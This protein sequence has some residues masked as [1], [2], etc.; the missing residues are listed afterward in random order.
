M[1]EPKIYIGIDVS[2]AGLD[3]ALHPSGE[4]WHLTNSRRGIHTLIRR[5][6]G[7]PIELLVVEA[8][9]GYEAELVEI[10]CQAG[11]PVSRV[12]PGRVRKFAQGL[13]W[14]AKTDKIDAQLLALFGEKAQP[15]RLVL[16]SPEEKHLSA[17]LKRRRQ[18]LD[19]LTAEQNRTDLA[20]PHIL[21]SIHSVIQLLQSQVD[22]LDAQ[23]QALIDQTPTLKHKRDLL[24]SVPGVGK[25]LS[26]AL[27]AQLPELGSCDRKQ[28]AALA[29][30]APFNHDSG[31]KRGKRFIRGGRSFLRQIL[32]MATITATRFNPV[33]KPFYQ[34]LLS[35][36]K[37]KKVAIIACMR[38]LL[39][40]LNAMLRSDSPWQ[41]A[42]VS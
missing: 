5:L 27:I 28:I 14:L 11:L 30:V 13:N 19:M 42:F 35:S 6:Q 34:H 39:T 2:K 21:A 29:G 31:P 33:L 22:D 17:L 1:K 20:D 41:P 26:A 24:Q 18:L 38:K 10:L 8:T 4:S 12:N 40:I 23:I 36:G 25:V 9:G 7:K 37:Q 32:Y 16:P 15:R 3:I